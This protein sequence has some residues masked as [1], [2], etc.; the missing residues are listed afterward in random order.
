[1]EIC[2]IEKKQK[3]NSYKTVSQFTIEPFKKKYYLAHDTI[4]YLNFSCI[5]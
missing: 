1:M 4:Q 5:I 2:I 3:I